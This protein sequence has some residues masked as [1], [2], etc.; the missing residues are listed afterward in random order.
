FYWYFPA[1]KPIVADPPLIIWLQGGPGSSSMIGLFY[2]MGPIGVTEQHKLFRRQ[3]TW[4]THY[5]MVFVDQPVGTGYSYLTPGYNQTHSYEGYTKSVEEAAQDFMVF[6][7]RFYE[8]YPEQR[9]RKLYI[10]GESYAGKYVPAFA[11]SIHEYNV[12]GTFGCFALAMVSLGN[13]LTHPVDQI[14]HH[15]DLALQFG[16]VSL[17]QSLEIAK[18]A[19]QAIDYAQTGD[20]NAASDARIKLFDFTK[21]SAGELNFYDLRTDVQN[22][23]SWMEQLLNQDS[24]KQALNVYPRTFDMRNQDVRTAMKPDIMKS[25][26]HLLPTLLE[27][28][29]V[30]LYQGQF[31]YR[32]GIPGNTEWIRSLNWTGQ[33]G[34][35]QAERK[36][37]KV[38]GHIAG[39]MT[40]HNSFTRVEVSRAGHMVPMNAPMPAL[41]MITKF[42]ED[43]I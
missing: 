21:A 7:K 36:I 16:I 17:E 30:L 35:L 37:W 2:E 33:S 27:N 22:D 3:V 20:W 1:Q 5:S 31:D 40:N 23:W 11:A 6:L 13:G 41:D 12:K 42:I 29:K 18:L 19:Q 15:A 28:Y 9:E 25:V 8:Q 26:I 32:D 10:A 4:N 43:Q 38:D 39:Y 34:F 14:K 24:M